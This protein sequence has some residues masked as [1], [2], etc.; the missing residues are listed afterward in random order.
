MLSSQAPKFDVKGI[1]RKDNFLLH[2]LAKIF[3]QTRWWSSTA[4]RVF[5]KEN[6]SA[7]DNCSW[8][9]FTICGRLYL[10]GHLHQKT[11]IWLLQASLRFK[12]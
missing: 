6:A 8:D 1:A 7:K 9:F 3:D 5:F 10:S 2:Q 4:L 12:P 11:T